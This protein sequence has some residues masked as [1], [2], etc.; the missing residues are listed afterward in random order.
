MEEA[1]IARLVELEPGL[2][3]TARTV[4]AAYF[5]PNEYR[6]RT[7]RHL[8]ALIASCRRRGVEVRGGVDVPRLELDGQ[9]VIAQSTTTA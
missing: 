9:H 8:K 5:L 7:P 4:K 6:I 1:N 2:A 3:S